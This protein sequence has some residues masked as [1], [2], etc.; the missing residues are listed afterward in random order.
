LLVL[1]WLATAGTSVAAGQD[2]VRERLARPIHSLLLEKES[3]VLGIRWSGE[4]FVDAPIGSEP[5]DAAVTLRRA[6]LRFHRSL[7]QNWQAKLS[8][9]YTKGG[10]LEL[11]DNYVLYA[12]WKTAL[13]KLGIASPAFSLESVSDASGLTFMETALPV[14][15]L[16]EP[17]GAG[18]ML[19]KRIGRTTSPPAARPWCC[20]TSTPRSTSG[21]RTTCTW[22]P[23]FPGASTRTAPTRAFARARRSPLPTPSSSIPAPSR[24]RAK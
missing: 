14:E 6:K 1:A 21:E 20:I 2:E 16:A 24:A 8:A 5:P 12:G 22:A 15:A 4:L 18:V 13:L 11:S 17:K 7:N 19:L 9:D 23:R 10:Q 3:P